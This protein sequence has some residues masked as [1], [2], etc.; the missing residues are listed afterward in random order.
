[1]FFQKR[2]VLTKLDIYFFFI[3]ILFF[4][5]LSCE[6]ARPNYLKYKC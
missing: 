5:H 3:A 1:M 2:V 6:V 4:V